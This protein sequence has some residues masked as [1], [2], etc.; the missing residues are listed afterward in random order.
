MKPSTAPLP[1]T[2]TGLRCEQRTP[3]SEYRSVC[4]KEA[5]YAIE[6]RYT[7]GGYTPICGFHANVIWRRRYTSEQVLELTDALV[8]VIKEAKAAE[9]A[10]EEE[11]RKQQSAEAAKRK[12]AI[13][14]RELAALG[15]QYETA[16]VLRDRWS[17]DVD[18]T[19]SVFPA[20]GQPEGHDSFDINLQMDGDPRMPAYVRPTGSRTM[21]V[22][23]AR[24]VA[25]ALLVVAGWAEEVNAS[26]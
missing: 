13:V 14:E 22:E 19:V 8:Q 24:E 7:R 18:I 23:Q 21:S 26:L 12:T 9:K 5:A 15:Q 10:A 17:D 16:L 3:N 2:D 25:E 11:Y 6:A 20:G 4:H 1:T